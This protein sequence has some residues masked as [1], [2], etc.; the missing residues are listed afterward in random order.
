MVTSNGATSIG[1]L[2]RLFLACVVP[3]CSYGCEV[4]SLQVFSPSSTR[5]AAKDLE[6][7]ISLQ[8]YG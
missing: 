2:L 1:I 7:E 4:W 5:P 6:K 8:C 3:V